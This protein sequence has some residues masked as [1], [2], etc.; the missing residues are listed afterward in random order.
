MT[1]W[2]H[3]GIG[4]NSGLNID[5]RFHNRLLGPSLTQV[6]INSVVDSLVDRVRGVNSK[7]RELHKFPTR[8]GVVLTLGVLASCHGKDRTQVHINDTMTKANDQDQHQEQGHANY[9]TKETT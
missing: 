9:N 4:S 8:L 7:P 6:M 3:V 5:D 2:R 1:S